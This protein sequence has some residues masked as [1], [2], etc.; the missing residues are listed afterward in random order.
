MLGAVFIKLNLLWSS[1]RK[2]FFKK[3]PIP[4]VEVSQCSTTQC[5]HDSICTSCFQVQLMKN[6]VYTV[7]LLQILIVAL[8]TG[9]LSY[10]NPF[11]R[12]NASEII[13]QLFAKCGPENNSPIW[14]LVVS[15]DFSII[16]NCLFS[17]SNYDRNN[18]AV[19]DEYHDRR[20]LSG[21]Y[22]AMWQLVLAALVKG[23]LTIFTFGMKVD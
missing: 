4:L 10:P 3:A 11:T 7:F 19:I 22:T 18:T 14:W 1:V 16:N 5:R 12:A 15:S 8:L 20:A 9:L 23:L 21:V 13:K 17:C 2:R 6:S